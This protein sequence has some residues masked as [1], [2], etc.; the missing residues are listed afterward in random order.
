MGINI[1]LFLN[2]SSVLM[3]GASTYLVPRFQM[4]ALTLAFLSGVVIALSSNYSI[5]IKPL[6]PNNE[7]EHEDRPSV[8]V[9]R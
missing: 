2:V 4:E 7:D 9:S 1:S 8:E 6:P 5:K 3:A